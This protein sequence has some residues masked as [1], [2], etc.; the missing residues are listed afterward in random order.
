M[1]NHRG[2][3][4][5]AS[6]EAQAG[7]EAQPDDPP[8]T[9][10]RARGA[11]HVLPQAP[12]LAAD[13][14]PEPPGAF[15]LLDP[16]APPVVSARTRA[17]R[18]RVYPD[19]TDAQWNDWTW[20]LKHRI[21]DQK[22]LEKVLRLSDDERET[23]EKLGD[24]LPVGIT[25]YYASLLDPD[26]ATRGLRL[27]MVPVAGEFE[28]SVGEFADPLDEDHDM[29]VPGL[30][31]RYPDRVLF[32]VTSFCATYCRYCT[33][34][35]I[36]GKTGEFHFDTRQFQKAIDYIAATPAVRDVLISGGDPL[37]MSDERLEWLLSRLRAIPHVE[38]IRIGSKVPSVLPMRITPALTKMLRKYHPLW[39]SIHVM[40]PDEITPEMA[41]GAGRLADAGIPLGSQTV[42]YKGVN[43]D[44]PTMMAMVRKLLRVRIR[45]YY[46][47]Q[48]DPIEGSAHMRTSVET[49]MKIVAGLRGFTTGYGV[50]TFVV[51]APGGGGKIPLSY[52]PIVGRE[53]DDLLL[54]N[55]EGDVYRYHDPLDAGVGAGA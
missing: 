25:P 11:L 6:V 14:G 27:T 28:T 23:V 43:D 31:H 5:S 18:E 47:Y 13:A 8:A 52:D 53:G 4:P 34:S 10:G 38:F 2:P 19:V 49:G 35:R 16:D 45:P 29:P 26:D 12:P 9:N 51:D 21:R 36:V 24:R 3:S 42:L 1:R 20:Q 32:L 39:M 33:R 30:V 17:F 41:Q 46:I 55:F 48:C 44:V 40:H 22:S 54:R 7:F 15:P 50:P 37:T